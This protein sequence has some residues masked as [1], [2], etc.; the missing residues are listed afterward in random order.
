MGAFGMLPKRAGGR[1]VEVP[2]AEILWGL[3]TVGC[4]LTLLRCLAC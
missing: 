3:L 1:L 2:I 4:L